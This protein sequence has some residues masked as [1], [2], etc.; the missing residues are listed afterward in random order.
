MN[1]ERLLRIL[2]ASPEVQKAI[3]LILDGKIK[4][5][6][7]HETNEPLLLGMGAAAKYLGVSRAT[8]WRMVQNGTLEKIEFMPGSFRIRRAD[9]DTLVAGSLRGE[10]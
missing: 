8:L 1:N 2:Q 7:T 3:D 6:R 5:V 4:T 10:Q 9:L